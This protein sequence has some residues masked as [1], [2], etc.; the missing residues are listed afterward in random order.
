VEKL[1]KFFVRHGITLSAAVIAGRS[2]PIPFKRARGHC[3]KLSLQAPLAK[4]AAASASTVTLIKGAL[5]IMAWTKAKMANRCQWSVFYSLS[6]PPLVTIKEIRNHKM[7][8]WRVKGI[9]PEDITNLETMAA[10][11][12]D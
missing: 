11:S 9:T 4:G 5:K 3:K 7:Y 6:E 1:R 10:S 2:P 12:L 8:A